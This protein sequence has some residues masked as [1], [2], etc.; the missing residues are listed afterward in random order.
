[1]VSFYKAEDFWELYMNRASESEQADLRYAH[2]HY[3]NVANAKRDAEIERLRAENARLRE[4][5]EFYAD[6]FRIM[7][8]IDGTYTIHD[9]WYA[10]ARAALGEKE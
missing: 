9:E 7:D 1:V 10:K 4:A 3:A 2:A 5:L 8:F 6:P